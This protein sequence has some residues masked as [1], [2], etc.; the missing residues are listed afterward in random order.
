MFGWDDR[1]ISR[2]CWFTFCGGLHWLFTLWL[3]LAGWTTGSEKRSFSILVGCMVFSHVR[4]VG[5]HGRLNLKQTIHELSQHTPVCIRLCPV[6]FLAAG[7]LATWS[8]LGDIWSSFVKFGFGSAFS[9][10]KQ[11]TPLGG[12][13]VQELLGDYV[14]ASTNFPFPACTFSQH[15]IQ[16]QQAMQRDQLGTSPL[17]AMSIT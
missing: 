10:S 11:I 12:C 14:S 4:S 15:V 2:L 5:G 17:R 9:R 3:H 6:L 1:S 7:F 16:S 8:L 13:L